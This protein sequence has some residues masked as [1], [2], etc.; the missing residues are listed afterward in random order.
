MLEVGGA[1][2]GTHG[3]REEIDDLFGLSTKQVCSQNAVGP[4]FNECLKTRIPPPPILP[5]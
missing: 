2:P 1:H 3:H 5:R 4:F